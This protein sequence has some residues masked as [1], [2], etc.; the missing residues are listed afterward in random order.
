MI[1]FF[2][3]CNHKTPS[4]LCN[5]N[6]KMLCNLRNISKLLYLLKWPFGRWFIPFCRYPVGIMSPIIIVSKTKNNCVNLILFFY[7]KHYRPK[8]FY[9]FYTLIQK[10]TLYIYLSTSSSRYTKK[11]FTGHFNTVIFR[12]YEKK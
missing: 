12:L 1:A 6:H 4:N 5:G 9:Y 3:Y 8:H 7:V 11:K 2:F 10:L